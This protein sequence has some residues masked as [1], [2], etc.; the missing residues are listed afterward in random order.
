MNL[1]NIRLKFK[2]TRI[3]FQTWS[4]YLY[5][6]MYTKFCIQYKRWL[7]LEKLRNAFHPHYVLYLQW[8]QTSY[9]V[10]LYI[11]NHALCF[12]HISFPSSN[13][14]DI[15]VAVFR[16]QI[17]PRISVITDITDGVTVTI[18]NYVLVELFGDV[19]LYLEVVDNLQTKKTWLDQHLRRVG[20]FNIV[21]FHSWKNILM[22]PL[23]FRWRSL[24][25]GK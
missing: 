20:Q 24:K 10:I 14:Y 13:G 19:H 1:D 4:T 11:L 16:G 5:L 22:L 7:K 2:G 6:W 9:Q 15:T 8:A 18:V 3:C 23:I 17:N 12:L 21:I 25:L